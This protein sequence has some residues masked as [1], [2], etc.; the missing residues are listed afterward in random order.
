MALCAVGSLL[1]V[2]ADTQDKYWAF[3]MPGFVIGCMGGAVAYV[4][5]NIGMMQAGPSDMAGVLG[6]MCVSS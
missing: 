6:A 2:F 1:L 3:V 4:V 5:C